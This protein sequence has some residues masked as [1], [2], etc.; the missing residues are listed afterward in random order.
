M[1]HFLLKK[2]WNQWTIGI[3]VLKNLAITVLMSVI[4]IFPDARCS[5]MVGNADGHKG[6]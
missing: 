6:C 2:Y 5:V 3:V 1:A 4:W